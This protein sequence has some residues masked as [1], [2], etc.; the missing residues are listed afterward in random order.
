MMMIDDKI[1][2]Q[3]SLGFCLILKNLIQ[4]LTAETSVPTRRKGT[5]RTPTASRQREPLTVLSVWIQVD[6]DV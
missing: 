2:N 5:Q 4:I 3:N 6:Q 1:R